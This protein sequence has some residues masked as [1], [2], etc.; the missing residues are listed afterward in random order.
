YIRDDNGDEKDERHP[1]DETICPYDTD[2]DSIEDMS[3]KGNM[4]I[5]DEIGDRLARLKV[6]WVGPGKIF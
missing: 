1:M 2:P 6:C 5:D 3:K 4:I